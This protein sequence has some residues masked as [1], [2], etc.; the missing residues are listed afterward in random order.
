MVFS[1]TV[2][3]FFFLPCVLFA[4]YAVPDKLKNFILF[5]FSLIFYSWG[6]PV[7]IF[8]ML[9]ST[10]FD[11]MNGLLIERFQI[12]QKSGAAKLVLICSVVVNLGILG[13]FKYINF[14]IGNLNE[15]ADLNLLSL[16]VSLPMGISFYTFQTMSY[17]IDVYR[18]NVCAQKNMISFGT[19][20]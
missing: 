11:Y 20:E 10:V 14:F 16:N 8:I 18:Q 4:Y 9:F 15:L 17:T 1:S 3:I 19:Y 2:F 12:R 13:F 6:E 5:L 7:Y